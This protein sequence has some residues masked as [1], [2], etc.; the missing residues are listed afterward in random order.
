MSAETVEAKS[1]IAARPLVSMAEQKEA[2]RDGKIVGFTCGSCGHEQ[3]SPMMRC[4][5]CRSKELSSREFSITGKVVSY[6]IQSVASEEFI[7]ETPFAFAVIQLDDGP[8]VSGW[9][10]WISRPDELP[11]GSNVEYT[12][13]YK[14]GMMFEKS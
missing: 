1:H 12:P 2:L 13:T 11:L 10:P 5:K 4:P 14:P 6:T 8:R 7:N 3:F 9:V